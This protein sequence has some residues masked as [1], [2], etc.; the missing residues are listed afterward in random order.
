[1]DNT[2]KYTEKVNEMITEAAARRGK[3]LCYHVETFGC[4]MNARDSEK[5]RGMLREM[6]YGEAPSEEEAD[7]IIYNTCTVREH[8]NL[9][10]YG[11]LGYLRALKEKKKD[12]VI[13][14]CG[15]MIQEK[16]QAD[17]IR[18]KYPFVDLMFGT[19]SLKDF[20]ELLYEVLGKRHSVTDI[21]EKMTDLPE[22]LPTVRKYPFK[23][24][25]NISYGCNNFCTYCIVPYVRGREISRSS[26]DIMREV[27]DLASR[28]VKE[29][30]F[31][32]QNVNSYGNDSPDEIN[33]PELLRRA[34]DVEGIERIRFMTSHPK[35]LSDE[36]IKVMSGSGKICRH[37]HLP[38]QSG[39]SRI[40]KAMGR[41]YTGEGYLDLVERIRDGLGDISLTTD[42]IVG[43]PGESEDDFQ[44][45]MSLI[46]RVGYDSVFTFKYSKRSGTPAASY[47]DQIPPDVVSER[48]DRLLCL[49]RK[50]AREACSRFEGRTMNALVEEMNRND[51]LVTGRLGCN[52]L[53]HFPGDASLIGRTVDV[54]LTKCEGFYYT[55][56]MIKR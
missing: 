51:G 4:Q 43:F 3:P 39:S 6:G 30:M 32:G 56:E 13:A 18:E 36:L 20:P 15:C 48:F 25:V 49:V 7:F 53:V 24:G 54:K 50:K 46:D 41:R 37:L 26:E 27:R 23:S 22:N 42:V 31:L 9:R 19:Y 44:D 35:D 29:I 52:L 21:R 5:L 2:G 14:L 55:G 16:G 38:V 28:G 12:M 10:I 34:E 17:I 45:T 8:A 33:F 40:L 1:M 47:K 11:R